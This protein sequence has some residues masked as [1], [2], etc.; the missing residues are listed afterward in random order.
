MISVHYHSLQFP[1]SYHS[2]LGC[3]I[4]L[5]P[6]GITQFDYPDMLPSPPTELATPTAATLDLD[7]NIEPEEERSWFYY[8]AEI[9][10]RRMM[11]RIMAVMSRGGEQGW[12][13]NIG[14]TIRQCESLNEQIDVW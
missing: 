7:S 10:Y 2:E 8:L 13:E 14:E 12:I 4:P 6:S 1:Y 9:S 5:P 3:E 11:N